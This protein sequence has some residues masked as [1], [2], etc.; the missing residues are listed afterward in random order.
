[1][2]SPAQRGRSLRFTAA[3]IDRMVRALRSTG[4]D[5][6]Q[7]A[8]QFGVSQAYVERIAVLRR[9]EIGGGRAPRGGPGRSSRPGAPSAEPGD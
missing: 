8:A 6:P 2:A 1:M 7:V 5:Y 3:D 4:C 9:F